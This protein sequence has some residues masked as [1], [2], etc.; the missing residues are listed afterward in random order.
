MGNPV[1]AAIRAAN[2]TKKQ[3]S[4]DLGIGT[5][6]IWRACTGRPIEAEQ[7]AR[8][9]ERFPGLDF[10]ALTLGAAA[11][12]RITGKSRQNLRAVR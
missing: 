8:L 10:A 2:V 11:K 9:V 6:T 3:L 12:R 7:A 4:H 5:T 1:E